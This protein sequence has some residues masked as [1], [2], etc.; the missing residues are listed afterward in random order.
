MQVSLQHLP[1]QAAAASGED[2]SAGTNQM[3]SGLFA[4]AQT[5]AT[6]LLA[7]VRR[8]RFGVWKWSL[9]SV[10]NVDSVFLGPSIRRTRFHFVMPTVNIPCDAY[11]QYICQAA[12]TAGQLLSRANNTHVTLVVER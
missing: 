10:V 7:K 12:A 11:R 3:F 2:P 8:Y 4:K 5:K 9:P 6:G 1:M